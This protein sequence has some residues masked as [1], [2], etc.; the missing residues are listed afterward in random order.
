MGAVHI[1]PRSPAS[2]CRIFSTSSSCVNSRG[3]GRDLV[4]LDKR[5][6]IA[7]GRAAEVFCSCIRVLVLFGCCVGVCW[8]AGRRGAMREVQGVVGVAGAGGSP[9]KRFELCKSAS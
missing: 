2:P 4:N 9:T 1:R 5:T 8:C 6:E 7:F 3:A